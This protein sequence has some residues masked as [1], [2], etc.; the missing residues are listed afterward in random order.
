MW[1]SFA[2]LKENSVGNEKFSTTCTETKKECDS[3][4]KRYQSIKSNSKQT[5]DGSLLVLDKKKL[6][7]RWRL[8]LLADKCFPAWSSSL[9]IFVELWW[10]LFGRRANKSCL[11]LDQT[12]RMVVAEGLG[13]C[14]GCWC[15]LL[16]ALQGQLRFSTLRVPLSPPQLSTLPS[17]FSCR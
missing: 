7:I 17:P 5:W 4:M 15:Y 8:F 1:T 10:A 11:Y 13:C 2:K 16:A 9:W 3:W 6:M 14:W 12:T